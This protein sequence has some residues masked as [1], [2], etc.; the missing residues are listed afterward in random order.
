M[1]ITKV[2]LLFLY[3]LMKKIKLRKIRLIFDI[4]KW[5][6]KSEFC[7][8]WPSIL[9]PLKLSCLQKNNF[10]H[11]NL[12]PSNRQ[13]RQQ[14]L[15]YRHIW[16]KKRFWIGIYHCPS[17]WLFQ[18]ANCPCRFCLEFALK[19][20]KNK[21]FEFKILIMVVNQWLI[22]MPYPSTCFVPVRNSNHI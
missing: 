22:L 19:K 12:H 13:E 14:H 16:P 10:E 7:C 17:V 3:S 21:I 15:D 2:A 1:T 8:I 6:W 5:L 20:N 9:K 4:E 11:T 18:E